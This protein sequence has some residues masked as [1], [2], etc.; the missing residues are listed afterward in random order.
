[1][2]TTKESGAHN[3][4][5]S[6]AAPQTTRHKQ[7]GPGAEFTSPG[8][9]TKL[10]TAGHHPDQPELDY[11]DELPPPPLTPREEFEQFHRSHPDVY[12]TLRSLAL[13]RVDR[14]GETQLSIN[15]LFEVA[16]WEV[17]LS[18][19]DSQFKLNN[20]HRAAYSRLLMLHEPRLAGLFS[21]RDSECDTWIAEVT[22]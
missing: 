10:I 6:G 7:V 2:T 3:P 11:P 19:G 22:P 8:R 17:S 14:L 9:R 12:A 1:V 13:R 5:R 18:T 20:D 16:R 15:M 4:V 21:T